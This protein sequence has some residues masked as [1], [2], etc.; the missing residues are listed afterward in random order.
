MILYINVKQ[1]GKSKSVVHKLPFEYAKTPKTVRELL[2]MTVQICV[3][4]YGE[5]QQKSESPNPLSDEEIEDQATVGR[6]AF[7]L[8]YNNKKPDIKKAV[9]TAIQAFKDGLYRVFIDETELEELDTELGLREGQTLTFIRLTM[10][11]G[12]TW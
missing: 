6:I 11:A 5:R 12:R 2:A 8:T 7:G 9:D 1:I 10:L 3:E 4:Q